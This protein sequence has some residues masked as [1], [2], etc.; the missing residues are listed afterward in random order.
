MTRKRSYSTNCREEVFSKTRMQP[1]A[2]LYVR[3]GSIEALG[4][5]YAGSRQ[6]C[7]TRESPASDRL[8]DQGDYTLPIAD[9]DLL[10]RE[11]A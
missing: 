5:S 8:V 1:V 2:S 7:G 4:R 11:R 3:T 9:H 6:T 10:T